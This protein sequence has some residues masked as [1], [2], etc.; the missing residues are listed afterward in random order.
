MTHLI[1]MFRSVLLAQQ[2]LDWRDMAG[3]AAGSVL[4]FA[5][6]LVFFSRFKGY[7]VDHE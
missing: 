5:T 6:G 2:P 3:F 7:I 4:L 1:D